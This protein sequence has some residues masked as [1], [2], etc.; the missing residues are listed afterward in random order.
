MG[1]HV[2]GIFDSAHGTVPGAILYIWEEN[3]RE[4]QICGRSE[5]VTGYETMDFFLTALEDMIDL[6]GFRSL[7]NS[8]KYS[9]SATTFLYYM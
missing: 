9:A 1:E 2:A 7:I 4:E 8:G 6:E 5:S 3:K